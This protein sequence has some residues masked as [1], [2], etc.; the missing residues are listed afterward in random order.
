MKS[1]WTVMH[2]CSSKEPQLGTAGPS[3]RRGRTAAKGE[4]ASAAMRG[5]HNEGD[6]HRVLDRHPAD[7]VVITSPHMLDTF[8]IQPPA[9]SCDPV[10]ESNGAQV[11]A[12]TAGTIQMTCFRCSLC[13]I[14]ALSK[15]GLLRPCF[16]LLGYHFLFCACSLK[17][18]IVKLYRRQ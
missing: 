7:S 18:G 10:V 16:I 1:M 5:A 17:L 8:T 2:P 9:T 6:A 14:E 11:L 15:C 4:T 12:P 3:G 13:A